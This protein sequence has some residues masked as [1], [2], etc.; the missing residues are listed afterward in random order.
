MIQLSDIRVFLE[1]VDSGS[2]SAAAR[3]L[4]MPKS[5]V[6]RQ[7]A[8]LEAEIGVALLNRSTRV[9]A[10]T[11][12]GR[13]FVPRARRLFDD[14]VEAQSAIR[15][16]GKGASGLLSVATTGLIGRR[17][18]APLLPDFLARHPALRIN[19]W[20]GAERREIG[21]EEGQVDVALRL[22]SVGAPDLGNRKL[23]EIGFSIVAAPT[24]LARR[25]VPATPEALADHDI[26]ELGPAQKHNRALLARGAESVSIVY[27]PR[28]QIDEPEGVHLA[29]LGAAGVAILPTFL[30]SADLRA[31]RLVELLRDW[32]QAPVPLHVLYRTHVSPPPRVRAFIDHL[33]ATIG[34]TQPW[35]AD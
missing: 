15:C 20:L 22:R 19:L 26:I 9:V 10:L 24:Y 4:R 31:G 34:R 18:I 29:V 32:R 35:A 7:M 12:E 6:A 8:R 3:V 13:D 11:P 28:L 27:T 23:G 17:F 5:S 25:G 21:P 2:F 14:A 33:F 30:V 1:I 16:E